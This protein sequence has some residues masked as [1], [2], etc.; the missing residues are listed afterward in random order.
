MSRHAAIRAV[1]GEEVVRGL[2]KKGI[3]IKCWSLRGIAEEAPLAYKDV[4]QVVNVVHQAELSKKVARL[5]PLAVIK[6]E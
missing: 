2:E 3:I 5:V 6:G 4:E 1:S